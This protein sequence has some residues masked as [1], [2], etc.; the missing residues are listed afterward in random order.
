MRLTVWMSRLTA[1]GSSP[2]V[3]SASFSSLTVCH[4][5]EDDSSSSASI[6][7]TEQV[8]PAANLRL[9]R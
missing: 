5:G 8:V 6:S 7:T 2:V 1:L 4:C 3:G 9:G